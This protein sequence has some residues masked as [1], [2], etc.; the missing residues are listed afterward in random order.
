MVIFGIN[1]FDIIPKD[2]ERREGQ[3]RM[4]LV[5]L[6][7]WHLPATIYKVICCYLCDLQS[8][9]WSTCILSSFS[10]AVFSCYD[11]LSEILS[12]RLFETLRSSLFFDYKQDKV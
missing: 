1:F 8:I 11:I 3:I 4:H 12:V 2:L 10:L 6:L 5:T 7:K 9:H